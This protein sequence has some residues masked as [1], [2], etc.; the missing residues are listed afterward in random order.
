[1]IIQND[2]DYDANDDDDDIDANDDDDDGV[3][4]EEK[5]AI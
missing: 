2:D 5:A 1:M 4:E 3:E